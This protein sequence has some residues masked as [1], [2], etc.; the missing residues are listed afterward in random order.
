MIH[1]NWTKNVRT[2]LASLAAFSLLILSV[3]CGASK[4]QQGSA[5]TDFAE[6]G[7]RLKFDSSLVDKGLGIQS[8]G[9]DES[10][11]PSLFAF[12]QYTPALEAL[13]KKLESSS[14]DGM[15]QELF[16]SFMMQ[17]MQHYKQLAVV[18]A[19]P[20]DEYDAFL[21]EDNKEDS[22]FDGMTKIGSH[23]DRVY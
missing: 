4:K 19:V 6:C 17:A 7:L 1:C 9:A 21:A 14:E 18:L 12:F 16:D 11:Y 5:Y 13:N 8:F 22:P 15:T 10:E 3:S 2:A 23:K 20:V